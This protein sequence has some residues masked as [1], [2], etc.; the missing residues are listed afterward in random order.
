MGILVSRAARPEAVGRAS[1][2]YD[3]STNASNSPVR[4]EAPRVKAI[5][6]ANGKAQ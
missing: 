2:G 3:G 6:A 4:W 5:M 1:A